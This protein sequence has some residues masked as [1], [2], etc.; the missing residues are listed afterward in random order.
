MIN[1]NLP[2]LRPVWHDANWRVFRFTGYGGLVAGPARLE[3]L[4]ADSFELDVQ[5][6]GTVTVRIHDSPRWAVDGGNACTVASSDGW[7]EIEHLV[8]G[9]VRVSQALRGTRCDVDK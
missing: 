5:R 3:S 4:T 7:L 8:P 9:E 2:H 1:G 6:A